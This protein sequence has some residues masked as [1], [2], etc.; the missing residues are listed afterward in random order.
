MEHCM[1]TQA[2]KLNTLSGIVTLIA[3]IYASKPG[4]LGEIDQQLLIESQAAATSQKS[5]NFD[6]ALKMYH[7]VIFQASQVYKYQLSE[8]L[9]ED[10]RELVAMLQAGGFLTKDPAVQEID[11]DFTFGFDTDLNLLDLDPPPDPVT[12]TDV[13]VAQML[14]GANWHSLTTRM[15]A[16]SNMLQIKGLLGKP[17]RQPGGDF[18][19]LRC[20]V[21][22]Y[23]HPQ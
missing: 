5:L 20:T 22:Q 8:E 12:E 7:D 19:Y 4:D 1:E 21:G 9:T 23:I 10:E 16:E 18:G 15:I 6:E 17:V 3:K 13:R 2:E 14:A 11:M